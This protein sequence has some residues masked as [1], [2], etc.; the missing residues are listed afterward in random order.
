MWVCVC[1]C[2]CACVCVCVCVC[3]RVFVR[4]ASCL[5]GDVLQV[6]QIDY[7]RQREAIMQEHLNK[8]R[9]QQV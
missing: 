8:A 4:A 7:S 3:A 1:V 6:R 5:A 9:S 2:V